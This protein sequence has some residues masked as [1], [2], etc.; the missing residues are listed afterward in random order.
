MEVKGLDVERW[1]SVVLPPAKV[2]ISSSLSNGL[3][4]NYSWSFG[5]NQLQIKAET[6]LMADVDVA[7]RTV[8]STGLATTVTLRSLG[9]KQELLLQLLDNERMRLEVWLYPV[10]HERRYVLPSLNLSK[11]YSEVK[12]QSQHMLECKAY[13]L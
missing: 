2:C 5:G 11:T 1:A 6:R 10:D 12:E 3:L 8:S 13:N 4:I 7:L 9:T